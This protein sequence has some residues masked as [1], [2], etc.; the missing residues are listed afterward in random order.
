[1]SN[2]MEKSTASISTERSFWGSLVTLLSQCN[3]IIVE[4]AKT[5]LERS[6]EMMGEKWVKK[7]DRSD[8]R[9]EEMFLS[10]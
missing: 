5:R 2:I 9:F 4:G 6:E 10:M 8:H 7:D 3:F 1:M